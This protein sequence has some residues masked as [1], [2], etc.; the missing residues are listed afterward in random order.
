MPLVQS[1]GHCS[2]RNHRRRFDYDGEG[3]RTIKRDEQGGKYMLLFFNCVSR[4]WGKSFVLIG[5]EKGERRTMEWR[6]STYVSMEREEAVE[7]FPR[8]AKWV[9][10]NSRRVYRFRQ[11]DNI[12]SIPFTITINVMISKFVPSIV[13]PAR[14]KSIC[15]LSDETV[16]NRVLWW[17]ESWLAPLPELSHSPNGPSP[18]ERNQFVINLLP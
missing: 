3:R 12:D 5:K 10:L 16:T 4:Q 18:P 2:R 13:K 17:I 6:S 1:E 14:F 11:D 8:S 15:L 7:A 9:A